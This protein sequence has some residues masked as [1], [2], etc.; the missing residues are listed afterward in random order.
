[1]EY[2]LY[3]T[4]QKLNSFFYIK[5]L[6]WEPSSAKVTKRYSRRLPE[7]LNDFTGK[8]N[9]PYKS[10]PLN[11]ESQNQAKKIPLGLPSSQI[12]I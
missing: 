12:E 5:I 10:R 11:L 8:L 4:I 7:Q 6:A 3:T 2:I 1:M 9:F